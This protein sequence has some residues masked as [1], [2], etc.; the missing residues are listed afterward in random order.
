[1]K[2]PFFTNSL[3]INNRARI[4]WLWLHGMSAREISLVTRFSVSTVYRVLGFS[5]ILDVE[6]LFSHDPQLPQDSLLHDPSAAAPQPPSQHQSTE[7]SVR[8]H[9]TPQDQFTRDNLQQGLWGDS[10]T[11]CRGLIL[12]LT[13]SNNATHLALRLVEMSGLWRLPETV[14]IAI[15]GRAGV[16]AVLLHHSLRN[17]VHA[18]YLALHHDLYLALNH[19]LYLALNHASLHTLPP[20]LHSLL[21]KLFTHDGQVKQVS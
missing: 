14:V 11:T 2:R 19:D 10:R 15:G 12:D 16:R 3:V 6:A 5:V 18:L 1:M 7:N 8:Q 13:S 21:G 9:L 4:V 17:T 20:N